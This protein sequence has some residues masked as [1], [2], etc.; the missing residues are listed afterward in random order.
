MIYD[1]ETI[2][3]LSHTVNQKWKIANGIPLGFKYLTVDLQGFRSGAMNEPL[4]KE[5]K[6]WFEQ[7]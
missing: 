7:W 4:A 5:D 3:P 6:N 1:L 2:P